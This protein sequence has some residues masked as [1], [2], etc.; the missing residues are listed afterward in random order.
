MKI[1]LTLPTDNREL[2]KSLVYRLERSYPNCQFQVK[3]DRKIEVQGTVEQPAK[4]FTDELQYCVDQFF[5]DS[6][7]MA[8]RLRPHIVFSRDSVRGPSTAPG[9]LHR[10]VH[11]TDVPGVHWLSPEISETIFLLDRLFLTFAQGLGA[12]ITS[13]PSLISVGDLEKCGYLPKEL[14]QVGFVCSRSH[15]DASPELTNACLSPAACLTTYP[16]FRSKKLANRVALTHLGTV[17]RHEGGRFSKERPLER[18]WEYQVRELIFFGDSQY[19]DETRLSYFEFL[20]LVAQKLDLSCEIS[21]AADLFFHSEYSSLATFQ[22][23]SASK[24]EFNLIIPGP[25]TEERL[26]LSSF[27]AHGTQFVNAFAIEGDSEDFQSFCIGFG[28]QRWLQAIMISYSDTEI[29]NPLLR[30][31]IHHLEG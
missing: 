20:K 6:A 14:H 30:E 12:K 9:Q 11:S 5:G 21:S 3:A 27:N 13:P 16:V 23:M 25:A 17:F 4:S 29:I 26:A 22:L 15:P 28:I 8:E 18:V 24:F 19:R 10:F 31:I 2:L 7:D 1:V